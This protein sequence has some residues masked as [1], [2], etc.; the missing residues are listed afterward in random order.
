MQDASLL[1][2]AHYPETL[3]RIFLI[4]APSFFPTVWGWVKRWFDPITVSKIFILSAA[5]TKSTL[6]EYIDEENIP[7]KYGG[8]L[9]FK[10]GDMPMLE[11]GIANKL[12]W[13]EDV[14]QG[15]WRSFPTGPIKWTHDASGN[16]VAL[17]VGSENGKRRNRVIAGLKPSD[18]AASATLLRPQAT[19]MRTTTGEAT[20]PPSPPPGAVE[21]PP[22]ADM[23][24]PE[25]SVGMARGVRSPDTILAGTYVVPLRDGPST[26]TGSPI[27]D[28]RQ[29]TSHTRYEQQQSTHAADTVAQG[30]P[31]VQ[32]RDHDIG[33]D[34]HAVMEPSTVGQA[35][36]EF[37]VPQPEEPLPTMID[38]AKQYAG[39]AYEQAAQ[40]PQTVMAAVGYGSKPEQPVEEKPKAEDPA[41]DKIDPRQLEEFLRAKNKSTPEEIK[42]LESK[43]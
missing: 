36:K 11:P 30:T 18:T 9:D 21:E 6:L 20:H 37:P 7:I 25:T 33:T 13:S 23:T 31:A 4:G 41:V 35:P 15:K 34:K 32:V 12:K 26:G 10:F 8:K 27:P 14:R 24:D 19:L 28:A 38:T 5:N 29:G 42:G 1:A 3:D 17:A 40:L 22:P 2:T 43:S 16:L 39:Q